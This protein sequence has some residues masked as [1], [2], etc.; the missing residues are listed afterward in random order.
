MTSTLV[1]GSFL[2]LFQ[3]YVFVTN[4][5]KIKDEQ[6]SGVKPIGI[7]IRAYLIFANIDNLSKSKPV[8]EKIF[9]N[10]DNSCKSICISLSLSLYIYIYI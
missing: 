5:V 7:S 10:V 3:C 6:L 1:T 2:G 8:L 4:G 9:E